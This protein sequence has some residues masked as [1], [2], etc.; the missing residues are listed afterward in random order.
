MNKRIIMAGATG[1][2]GG[3]LLQ[4][5]LQ[6]EAVVHITSLLR[7]PSGIKHP[8]LEEVLLD[9]FTDL[10]GLE[11]A[12]TN[13][14]VAY[15]CLGVYT[16]AVPRATFRKITVDMPVAFAERLKTHSP[17]ARLVL[18]SG[19]GA[20]RSEKS[21]MMF[22]KDK[23][24]AENRLSD[25][26]PGEFHTVRPGYIYPVERRKAPNFSYQL[27]RSLYPL[28]RLMGKNHSIKSTDL[29]EAIFH[30]GLH[31]APGEVLENREILEQLK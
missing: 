14:E 1:M 7:K 8:K 30:I 3:L 31:G 24:A 13:K 21:R 12:F 6:S 4:H 28:V 26:F 29:A 10:S 16:G 20:D 5:C 17:N 18:L 27:M 11:E 23:G 2:V 15:F 9:D 25:L 22:A 19:A